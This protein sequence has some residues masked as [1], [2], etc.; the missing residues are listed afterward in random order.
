MLGTRE[1]LGKNACPHLKTQSGGNVAEL[2]IKCQ[3]NKEEGN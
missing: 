2:I 3:V 1:S